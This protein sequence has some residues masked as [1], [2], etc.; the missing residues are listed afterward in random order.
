MSKSKVA[1]TR[2]L[3]PKLK[4]L[5]VMVMSLDN[6]IEDLIDKRTQE[7]AETAVAINPDYAHTGSSENADN[8]PN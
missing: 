1:R 7:L 2:S 6:A 8:K 4:A 5:R 3:A